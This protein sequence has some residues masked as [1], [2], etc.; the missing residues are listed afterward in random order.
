MFKSVHYKRLFGMNFY[1]YDDNKYII[2]FKCKLWKI[3]YLYRNYGKKFEKTFIINKPH[4]T[5]TNK[6]IY[7][8]EFNN[9]MLWIITK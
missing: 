7:K 1:D 3:E 6:L 8:I 2:S 5:S 9:Y 4:C